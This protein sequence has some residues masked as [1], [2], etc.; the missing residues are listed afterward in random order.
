MMVSQFDLIDQKEK[1]RRLL[2]AAESLKTALIQ[3]NPSS[4]YASF[5][6]KLFDQIKDDNEKRFP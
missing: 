1:Y 4:E 6:V 2:E 5:L 3:L